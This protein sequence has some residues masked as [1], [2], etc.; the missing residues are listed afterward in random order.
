MDD[1]QEPLSQW[2]PRRGPGTRIVAW[3]I[4]AVMFLCV[5]VMVIAIVRG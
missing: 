4:L 5:A 3:I 2:R 1:Q